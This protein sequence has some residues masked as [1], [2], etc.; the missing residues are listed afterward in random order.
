MVG[1]HH[2]NVSQSEMPSLLFCS[3]LPTPSERQETFFD[4]DKNSYLG[5]TD[6]GRSPNGV[7]IRRQRQLEFMR[8][9]RGTIISIEGSHFYWYR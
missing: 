9:E 5:H 1:V 4:I 8:K 7:L 3:P 2:I 6:S